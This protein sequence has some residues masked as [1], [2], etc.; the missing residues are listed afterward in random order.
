VLIFCCD[1]LTGFPRG[2]RGNLV[3]AYYLICRS[4]Y[5][6]ACRSAS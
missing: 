1:G 6:L 2:D 5:D 4:P 3:S